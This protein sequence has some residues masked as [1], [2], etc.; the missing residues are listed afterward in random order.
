M[1]SSIKAQLRCYFIALCDFVVAKPN[2]AEM[3]DIRKVSDRTFL[4]K[5]SSN[6]LDVYERIMCRVM[7]RSGPVIEAFDVEGS[8]E[9]RV[10]MGYRQETIDSFF[11]SISDLYHYYELFSTRKYVENFSNGVTIMTIYLSPLATAT[12]KSPPIEHA[13]MQVLKEASL[14]Y[15]VPQNPL[16]PLF[17]TGQLSVQ[18]AIYGF[19]A[20]IFCQHFLNRLGSEYT[21]LSSMVDANNPQH[22][23]VLMKLKKRLRQETFTREYVLEIVRSYP[24]LIRLLYVNFAM[25]HYTSSS[26]NDLK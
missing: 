19:S 2:E 9:K 14:I 15:C 20:L 25:V 16:Q 24:E 17:Q 11:S 3:L 22:V 13:I 23:E 10:V 21:T 7:E 5:A 1:S 8:R 26:S 4:S 12:Q 6:T 18:E